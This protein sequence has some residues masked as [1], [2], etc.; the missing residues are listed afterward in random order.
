MLPLVSAAAVVLY[1]ALVAGAEPAPAYDRLAGMWSRLHDY[2][3]TIDSHEVLGSRISDH[4]LHYAYRK[5]DRAKLEVVTG[6]SSGSTI[7]WSGGDS[8]VAY[9]RGLRFFKKHGGV[10]DAALTS[11]R[12]NGVLTPNLGD[13]VACFGEHRGALLER[14]GPLVGEEATD[15]IE[16]PYENVVCPDDSEADRTVTRDVIDVSKRTGLVVQ[17]T[18]YVGATVVEQWNLRNYTVDAGLDDG[19]LR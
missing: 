8:V 10:K 16:L 6:V 17:R 15:E 14:A 13:I 5:P 18:R 4:E 19:A 7:V 1:A 12:G 9:R 3:V 11:L 2:T